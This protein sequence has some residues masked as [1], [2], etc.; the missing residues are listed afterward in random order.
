MPH[1]NSSIVTLI[2]FVM[3]WRFPTSNPLRYLLSPIQQW[4]GFFC[5]IIRP[6]DRTRRLPRDSVSA[7]RRLLSHTV[8]RETA[9][10][11][12]ALAKGYAV[13]SR[14]C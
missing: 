14:I 5:A 4:S 3:C 1:L 12:P 7:Q 2:L 6:I 11:A 9:A 13:T 8:S 10:A